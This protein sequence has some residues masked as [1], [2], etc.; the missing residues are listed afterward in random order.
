MSTLSMSG[1]KLLNGSYLEFKILRI[2]S[3]ATFVP[4]PHYHAI[5][6]SLSLVKSHK[7]SSPLSVWIQTLQLQ[8]SNVCEYT[9]WSPFKNN[10]I[11]CMLNF[12]IY[13]YNVDFCF[14]TYSTASEMTH[15]RNRTTLTFITAQLC[16]L[17]QRKTI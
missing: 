17:S 9:N 13:F 6:L 4:L 10:K 3:I 11:K 5:Y 12:H 14:A 1:T 2:S 16:Q 7:K 8:S 15:L